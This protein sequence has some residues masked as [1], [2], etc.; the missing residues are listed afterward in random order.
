MFRSECKNVNI[1]L[2]KDVPNLAF[3]DVHTALQSRRSRSGSNISTVNLELNSQLC[4][5]L[6]T[7]LFYALADGCRCA[8]M[9]PLRGA[10]L[11]SPRH[12]GLSHEE[13]AITATPTSWSFTAATADPHSGVG[14]MLCKSMFSD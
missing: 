1:E 11:V 12:F 14:T 9:S 8:L 3:Q 4:W 7:V 5:Q 2:R 6:A 10:E 13:A